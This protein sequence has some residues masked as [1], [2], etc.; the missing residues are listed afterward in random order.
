MSDEHRKARQRQYQKNFYDRHKNA[1]G[2]KITVWL[3]QDGMSALE[4]LLERSP[5]MGRSDV[6]E[7][8]LR[9]LAIRAKLD[10]RELEEALKGTAEIPAP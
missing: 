4:F 7:R 6:V 1:G 10:E 2:K 5:G 3:T 9:Y 8:A